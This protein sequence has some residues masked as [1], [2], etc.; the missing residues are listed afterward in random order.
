[1]SLKAKLDV[2]PVENYTQ[3]SVDVSNRNGGVSGRKVNAGIGSS[4]LLRPR[5]AI[6]KLLSLK[7]RC[8]EELCVHSVEGVLL[9]HLHRHPHVLLMKQINARSRDADGMRTVPPSNMNAE[10]M[11]RLPGGRCRRGEAEEGCLLR[12]LGR[13]LLNEAKTPAGAS[14][15]ANTGNSDTVVDVGMAHN[16]SKAGRFF[17]IGEVLSTWY[18]P[19]F[20]PHMYPYVPAHIAASSVRE[21]RTVYLVHVEPTVYFNMVQEGVELVA[22]PLF[23]LYENSSKYGPI[24]SSLP[25][26]LS[27]VLINYCS[28]EY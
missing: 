17:R 14:E 3:A 22:A 9:V 8:E 6:E 4:A 24:I 11:Y 26:L 25:V 5:N 10:V 19:H 23:D 1:M 16:A 2:Y 21:V 27:R 18:R 7:K 12:K 28:T 13:H 15:V 20:T